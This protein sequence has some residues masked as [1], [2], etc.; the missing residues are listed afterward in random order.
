MQGTYHEYRYNW[1]FG[2]TTEYMNKTLEEYF[3]EINDYYEFEDLLGLKD[4]HIRLADNDVY[5]R[6][7]DSEH[8]LGKR[9]GGVN[10][11]SYRKLGFMRA[12]WRR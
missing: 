9:R 10:D 11:G 7:G 2:L 12:K 5:L 8:Y 3:A 1:E 6:D 4:D